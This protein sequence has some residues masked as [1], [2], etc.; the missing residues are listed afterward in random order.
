MRKKFEYGI[1]HINAETGSLYPDRFMS[2]SD[3]EKRADEEAGG[4][5]ES[6]G[7]DKWLRIAG[8]FGWELC[9]S[10]QDQDG[11]LWYFKREIEK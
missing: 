1:V 2:M 6:Y 9:C 7:Q 3:V 5:P 10:G 11:L 8:E 4:H